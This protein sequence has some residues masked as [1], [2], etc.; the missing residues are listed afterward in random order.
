MDEAWRNYT[1]WN[2]AEREI[3]IVYDLTD[4][5]NLKKTTELIKLVGEDRSMKVMHAQHD[6]Y[7]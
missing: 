7:S 5:W 3:Q 4:M 1:K 2:K 6:D